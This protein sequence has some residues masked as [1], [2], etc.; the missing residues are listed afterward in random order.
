MPQKNAC[1]N[2]NST[3]EYDE[4]QSDN[5]HN[6]SCPNN[7]LNSNVINIAST[8]VMN[9]S[10]NNLSDPQ[11]KILGKGLK[12]CPIKSSV[13]MADVRKELDTF[14]NRLPSNRTQE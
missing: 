1:F 2:L 12:C 14:H 3:L 11:L 9:L 8:N 6:E 13:E 10:K 5:S 4:N 7:S